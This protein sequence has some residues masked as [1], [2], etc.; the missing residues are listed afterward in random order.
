MQAVLRSGGPRFWLVCCLLSIAVAAAP[1]GAGADAASTAAAPALGKARRINGLKLAAG[2]AMLQLDSGLLAPLV[3]AGESRSR[4]YVF[5]GKGRL[6]LRP[7]DPVEAQQLELFHG[8]P[9]LDYAF[10]ELAL[11]VPLRGA[12][13][14]LAKRPEATDADAAAL[15]KLADLRTRWLASGE[16]GIAGVDL[17]AFADEQGHPSAQGYF[18][19]WAL[20][21]GQGAD[22]EARPLLYLVDPQQR[23][24]VTL[25]RFVKLDLTQREERQVERM[26]HREQRQGRLL[27][28]RTEEMG[29]FDTWVSTSLTAPDGKPRPGFDPFE[30]AAYRLNVRLDD[31]LR[32]HGRAEV[33]VEAQ[34]SGARVLFT[35][36]F[37][38]LVVAKVEVGGQPATFRRNADDLAVALPAPSVAG[39]RLTVTVTYDGAFVDKIYGIGF[40]ARDPILW[41][42]HVGDVDRATYDVELRWPKRLDLLAGGALVDAGEKGGERWERRQLE[43]PAA[44]FGFELGRFDVDEIEHGDVTLRVALDRASRKLPKE[45]RQQIAQAAGDALDLYTTTFGPYPHRELTLVTVPRD[46]SQSLPGLI[47]LS[48]L[49]MADLGWIGALLGFEDRRTVV[50]HEVAHQW[51]G[52]EVGWQS[53]HDMWLSESLASWSAMQF[54]REKL[55]DKKLAIGPTFGWETL[56]LAPLADGRRVESVGPL[57]LGGRLESTLAEGAYAAIVYKK[58]AIVL[59]MLAQAL[60]RD[61]FTKGLHDLFGIA[62]GKVISTEVL[63]AALQRSSGAELGS[64][65]QQFVYGTGLPD[66]SY[67]YTFAPSTPGHWKVSGN[68]RQRLPHHYR[69][70]VDATGPAGR[71]DVVREPRGAADV[72]SRWL[73]V[74]FQIGVLDAKAPRDKVH[75]LDGV[76]T[77]GF[78]V[79][80]VL[81]KGASS[82]FELEVEHEPQRLWLDRERAVLATFHDDTH[83]TKRARYRQGLEA[84]AKGDVAAA[85]KLWKEAVAAKPADPDEVQHVT[86]ELDAT[87]ELELARLRLDRGEDGEA[88][89][90]VKRAGDRLGRWADES[91]RGEVDLLQSRLDLRAGRFAE[92]YRRLKKAVLRRGSIDSPEAHLLLAV[93]ALRSGDRHAFDD[94]MAAAEERG[95]D[96]KALREAAAKPAG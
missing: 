53:Y 11:F 27:G 8:E 65:A 4:E 77:S 91:V 84:A 31:D 5:V 60:G 1:N 24:Q 71:L 3:A 61:A 50:A 34:A 44:A 80:Q 74:P 58:G 54:A 18:V 25:G 57:T 89:A 43:R 85:E 94:A 42:P 17:Q 29:S 56:L 90:A 66:M 33:D 79:G 52:H 46:Y 86:Q 64:F 30:A 83:D 32:I 51:W 21:P 47:T 13:D 75:E 93:A 6:L 96:V 26:L 68:V 95:A 39:E 10:E 55:Q 72:E 23:E 69:W 78:V 45:A 62:A 16:R 37:R 67:D 20:Q 15:E 9:A 76:K 40:A 81:A 48:D 87:I 36:L 88:A 14:A 70:R 59:D 2:A 73:L 38:D 28:L 49:M 41:H 12:G 82:P 35:R 22:A 92:A 7:Q 19:A 63:L